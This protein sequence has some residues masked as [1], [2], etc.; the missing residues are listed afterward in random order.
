MRDRPSDLGL[1]PYGGAPVEPP[2]AGAPTL[3]AVAVLREAMKTGTFWALAVSFFVCGAT[4]VGLIA[5]HFIP[6]AHDHGMPATTAA[7][8][9]AVM[10]I[11]DIAGTTA[12]GWLTDR[13]DPRKLL[14]WYYALR[15]VSLVLLSNALT[16]QSYTLVLFVAFYGLDWIA[17]V[18][19]TVAITARRFGP[20]KSSIV[21][22][23]VFTFHQ[24]GGAAAAYGAGLVRGYSGDYLPVFI[25][26]G[27][28]CGIAALVV[29][30]IPRAPRVRAPL[31]ATAPA[32]P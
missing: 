4:T 2:R 25:A 20:E 27:V 31:P 19:P 1:A 7:G 22:G 16:T 24:L 26:S 11:L 5:V 12:S 13:M 23:W 15:G 8:M 30:R 14:F 18:P 21:F 6:A 28:L 9:L 10:G 32:T 29:L 3:S 17:T